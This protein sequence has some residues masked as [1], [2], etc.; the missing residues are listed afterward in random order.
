[1]RNVESFVISGNV[2][3]ARSIVTSSFRL[4]V[5]IFYCKKHNVVHTFIFNN[6]VKCLQYNTINKQKLYDT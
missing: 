2:A 5:L 6:P 1:M 3:N 4:P